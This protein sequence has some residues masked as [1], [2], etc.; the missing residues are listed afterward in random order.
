MR[1]ALTRA[2]SPAI[3]RCELTHLS[4]RPIDLRVAERQHAAYEALL[5]ELGCAV[6]RLPAEP[7][8]PDSVFV[9]DAAV[10]LDE[11]AVV[12]RPGAPSRRAE[13]ETVARALAAHRPIASLSAPATLDG[14]DVLC[15]GR[16]IRVG[17][18][19]RTNDAGV[20]QLRALVEPHGY[21]VTGVAVR[22]CLH[23]KSAVTRIAPETLLIH[24]GWV[25]P[26][27]FEGLDRIE[28]DPAE[29]HAANALLVGETVIHPSAFPRTGE[30]LASR[31]IRVRTVDLS[32]LAKAEGGVT[33]CSVIFETSSSPG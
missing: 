32:E 19:G 2:V 21:Q 6:E 9:E 28:I 4:R 25:D 5:E 1:L 7:D 15:V 20:E 29:P 11:L 18:S 30:R 8:L 33:C 31:G 16:R 12:T 22:G 26:L 27:E 17:L 14:G 3:A 23:L 13:T 24:P 10:V